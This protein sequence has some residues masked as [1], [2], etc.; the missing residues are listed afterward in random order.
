MHYSEVCQNITSNQ[1][2]ETASYPKKIPILLRE[3]LTM[4][5]PSFK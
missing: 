2:N 4:G 3:T 5:K 1:M